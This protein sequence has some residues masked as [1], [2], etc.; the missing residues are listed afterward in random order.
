VSEGLA[1]LELELRVLPGVLN[2]GF[3]P[4]EQGGHV[5]ISVVAVDPEPDLEVVA[6]RVARGFRGAATVEIHD[7][8]PARPT[9]ASPDS[10]PATV[11]DERVALVESRLDEATGEAR[12]VLSWKG[13]SANGKGA[14]GTLVGPAVAT[15]QALAGLGVAIDARLAS[16]SSAQGIANPPVRV[17]LRAEHGDAEFVGVARANNEPE[18]AARATLAAFNRYVGG[19]GSSFN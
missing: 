11:S 2:V 12:V 15:L 8:S 10:V 14:S 16:V 3:G 13:N 4:E 19:H 9:S 18:S 7:L 6:T 5:A 1:E 17:V